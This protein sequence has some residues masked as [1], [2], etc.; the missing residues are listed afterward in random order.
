MNLVAKGYEIM[1][2]YTNET[3]HCTFLNHIPV[4]YW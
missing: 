1:L 2:G 3:L 4:I